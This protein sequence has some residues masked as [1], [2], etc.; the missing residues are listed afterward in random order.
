MK[1]YH[2]R[3]AFCLSDQHTI[4]HGG[5]GQFAKSFVETFTPLGYK[6]DIITDKPTSNL[7]F[8]EYLEEAGANF[9]WSPTARSY[10]AHT[11]TFMFE[12][13]YNF[14]KM[15]SFRD[16]MMYALNQNLYDI[17]ICNTLESFPG[18]YALNLHKSVQVIYYTHNESMV[19]LDDRSWKNEFTESFNELFNALMRVK[20]ITIGTQTLRNRNELLAQK[21][22]NSYE[23]P[24][25]MTEK[26]LL[27]E[28]NKDRE[29][30]LWIGRWEPRKNPEEFIRVIKETGLPAKVITNTNGAKKFE[31]A[32]KAIDAKY[33]IKIGIYGQE[34]VDFI[35]SARVA[36]NPA[37][38]ESFGLAFYECMG[39]LPTVALKG[40]SWLNNFSPSWYFSADKKDIPALIIKLYN[41]YADSKEWYKVSPLASIV[42]EHAMGIQAWIDVFESFEPVESNSDRATI[43]EHSEIKYADYITKLNRKDLAVDDVRSVLTNKTKFNIIYTEHHTYLSKDPNF[44]PKEEKTYLESLFE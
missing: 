31:D 9:I 21:L 26:A 1:T 36:Y 3:I 5:L 42:D 44:V 41:E 32:L 24:I 17:I 34:K 6:I 15:S 14:E 38:R 37:I 27:Q 16:A 20:G 30:V 29:G 13:S 4:P 10:S 2:K 25:P 23:L 39:Q 40:M 43:N 33:E 12:D 35:T 11:K 22:F 8:K 18:I 28:H 19:F 7:A